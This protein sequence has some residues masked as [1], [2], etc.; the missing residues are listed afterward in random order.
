MYGARGI[1]YYSRG[2]REDLFNAQIL[3]MTGADLVEKDTWW[4]L[5]SKFLFLRLV[6]LRERRFHYD[7][8]VRLYSR[9]VDDNSR[10]VEWLLTGSSC[11][12]SV[13]IKAIRILSNTPSLLCRE[14]RS[15]RIIVTLRF[16]V[17]VCKHVLQI[18]CLSMDALVESSTRVSVKYASARFFHSLRTVHSWRRSILKALVELMRRKICVLDLIITT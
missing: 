10:V 14:L 11:Q 15:S 16:R 7:S 5:L 3:A 12:C 18:E 6:T 13:I 8:F 9:S 1:I 17:C 4:T 2:I